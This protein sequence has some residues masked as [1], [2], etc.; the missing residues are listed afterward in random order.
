MTSCPKR[1]VHY[2]HEYL[3]GDIQEEAKKELKDHIETCKNCRQHFAELKKTI[4][5]VQSASHIA[6]PAGFTGRV[7]ALLPREGKKVGIERWFK[8]HPFLT[9]AA[10]FLLL[11]SGGFAS[12]FSQEDNQFAF[13][14][15]SALKVENETVIVPAGTVVEE[16]IVVKNGDI[17]IEGSVDGNV[18]VING[19]RFMASAG[20]V[21]GDIEEIDAL[22]GRIW[23]EIKMVFQ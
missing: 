18:T 20:N 5:L 17:R 22:F 23:Y 1:I 7:M 13:T 9:A 16:D 3:D 6:A 2:M 10:L 15:N 4:A 8:N 11:M 14:K 12:F 19:D 21:T